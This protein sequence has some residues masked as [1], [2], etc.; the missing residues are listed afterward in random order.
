MKTPLT[1]LAAIFI[2]LAALFLFSPRQAGAPAQ[3]VYP[4]DIKTSGG[5]VSVFGVTLGST[6]LQQLMDKLRDEGET[7]IFV[8]P[9]KPP[10]VEAFFKS[11]NLGGFQARIIAVIDVPK[12]A[13]ENWAGNAR[14]MSPQA[15]GARKI[16]LGGISLEQ[17]KQRPVE[18]MTYLPRVA[19]D[20]TIIRQRFGKPESIASVSDSEQYWFYPGK[21]LILNLNTD[22][23]EV[24]HYLQPSDYNRVRQDILSTTSSP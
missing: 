11:I 21:G 8:E 24:L 6:P 12:Q 3:N 18:A 7:A 4:W 10:T 23:R 14:K 13:I 16:K 19:Y 9:D 17:A 22:S 2:I 1:I 15:S 5:A 20:E